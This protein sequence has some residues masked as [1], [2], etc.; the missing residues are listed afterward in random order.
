MEIKGINWKNIGNKIK[1]FFYGLGMITLG[2]T[3]ISF[4]IIIFM[5]T[6]YCI[7]SNTLNNINYYNEQAQILNNSMKNKVYSNKNEILLDI[8]NIVDKEFYIKYISAYDI[9]ELEK[10]SSKF[11]YKELYIPTKEEIKIVEKYKN[12]LFDSYNEFR[13]MIEN[14]KIDKEFYEIIEDN[15]GYEEDIRKIAR[16]FL[17]YSIGFT[18]I[19]ILTVFQPFDDKRE[20]QEEK[21]KREEKEQPDKIKPTWEYGK[22]ELMEQL[23]VTK[24]HIRITF[25]C[26]IF[27]I[28]GGLFLI[29]KIIVTQDL[30]RDISILGAIGG[31]IAE[32]IGGTLLL[33]YKSLISQLNENLK[34]LERLNFVGI[35]IKILDTIESDDKEEVNSAKMKLAQQ[36]IDKIQQPKEKN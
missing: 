27:A 13:F 34:I 1:N 2:I 11:T 30:D 14:L 35:G 19:F 16:T 10:D 6:G 28:I 29:F 22:V 15:I 18:V 4:I 3:I 26:S 17:V 24:K 25:W 31:V 32:F 5:P 21:I 20:Q 7:N 8:K 36:I 33:M 12:K 23:E 9:E